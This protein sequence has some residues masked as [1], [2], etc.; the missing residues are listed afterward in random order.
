MEFKDAPSGMCKKTY[1]I[2]RKLGSHEILHM[3]DRFCRRDALF[4]CEKKFG[5]KLHQ[6]TLEWLVVDRAVLDFLE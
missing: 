5:F 4:L 6:P 2:G 1:E 3:M